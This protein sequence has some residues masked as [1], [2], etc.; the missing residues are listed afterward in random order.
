MSV[1][2]MPWNVNLVFRSVITILLW[3]ASPARH[4][5][6]YAGCPIDTYS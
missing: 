6:R 2:G 1:K 3:P 4:G 5:R